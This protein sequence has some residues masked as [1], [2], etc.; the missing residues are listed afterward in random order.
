MKNTS[1]K[2]SFLDSVFSS[3]EIPSDL[4]AELKKEYES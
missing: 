2:N 4:K 1:E 3:S